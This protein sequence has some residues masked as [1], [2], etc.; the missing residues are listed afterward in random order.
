MTTCADLLH[1][2]VR[3]LARDQTRVTTAFT[4]WNAREDI[5]QHN[6]VGPVI[7]AVC[8]RLNRE[9]HRLFVV[10]QSYR[11]ERD[12]TSEGS[13]LGEN[14]PAET[15]ETSQTTVLP[16]DPTL[17]ELL[18]HGY[19][20]LEGLSTRYASVYSLATALREPPIANVARSSMQATRELMGELI[21]VLPVVTIENVTTTHPNIMVNLPAGPREQAFLPR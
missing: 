16:R 4:R 17:V 5:R 14:D 11:K 18:E 12:L 3:L 13:K 19:A 9:Q 2:S 1:S 20:A 15:H 7:A 21:G 10:W 8:E 6:S